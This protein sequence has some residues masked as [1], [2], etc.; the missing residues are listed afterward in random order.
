MTRHGY[1]PVVI[2][3]IDRGVHVKIISDVQ[4]GD[5]TACAETVLMAQLD[6]M[7]TLAWRSLRSTL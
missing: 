4:D 1:F 5:P 3:D 2:L 7:Q 6:E